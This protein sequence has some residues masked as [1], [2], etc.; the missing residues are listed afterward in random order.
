MELQD[1]ASLA[2]GLVAILRCL[3]GVFALL[4]IC[5]AVIRD[6]ESGSMSQADLVFLPALR[7]S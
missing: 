6:Q 1:A 2:M 3:P 5:I 7:M 4:S